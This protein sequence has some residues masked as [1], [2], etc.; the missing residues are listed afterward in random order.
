MCVKTLPLR[1]SCKQH[2][3]D[4]PLVVVII[5]QYLRV[6]HI[7]IVGSGRYSSVVV[8]ALVACYSYIFNEHLKDSLSEELTKVQPFLADI[9]MRTGMIVVS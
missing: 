7:T 8:T 2:C 6:S 9:L 5:M 3:Q 4:L 1:K